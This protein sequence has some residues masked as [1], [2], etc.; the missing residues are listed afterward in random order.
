VQALWLVGPTAM[1]ITAVITTVVVA[2][3]DHYVVPERSFIEM[4]N[5]VAAH[6]RAHPL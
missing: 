4:L 5:K 3:L 1:I 2:T 6:E